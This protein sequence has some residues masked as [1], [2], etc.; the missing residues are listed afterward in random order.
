MRRALRFGVASL[1]R[2]PVLALAGWSVPE[3]VPATVSGLAVAHAVD[4]GFLAGRPLTGLGWLAVLL[5]AAVV[6]S[7][8]ARQGYRRLGDIVEPFRDDLVRR[9]VRGALRRG[10]AGQRDDGAVARLTHQ[11]EIVRDAYAGLIVV[12]RSFVIIVIGAVIGLLSLS[13]VIL[14]LVMPPF[15]VGFG[16]FL[17]TLGMAAA[18]QRD[19][20]RADERLASTAGAVLAGT[21]DVVACGIEDSATTMVAVP[22]AEQVAAERA[23]ARVQALRTVCYAVGGWVPLIVLLG[24]GPWLS[25][26]GLTTGDIMG[27]LLYVLTGLQPALHT[28]VQSMSGSGLRFAVVL[29]RILDVTEPESPVRAAATAPGPQAG[30][31][32]T[33]RGITFAYGPHAAPVLRGLDLDVPIGDHLAVVGPSGIGKSTLA[34]IVCGLLQPDRGTIAIGGAATGAMS[35]QRLAALRVLI[36]QEAYVFAGTV[37][38]NLTYL[39]PAATPEQVSAATAAVGADSLVVGLGGWAATVAPAELSAG[40]RQLL[41]LVRAY[42]SPAPIA[43]LDEATCHLDPAAERRAEEAFARRGGTLIVIAH[44]ISSALRARRILVL[45]GVSASVGDHAT[46]LAVSPLYRDLLGYWDGGEAGRRVP[47]PATAWPPSRPAPTGPAHAAP[48]AHAAPPARPAPSVRPAPSAP[49]PARPEV[50]SPARPDAPPV[51]SAQPAQI[52]QP[53]QIQPAQIQP[54]QIQPAS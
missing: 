5:A 44:R 38:D 47:P 27:G 42:L 43:V 53:A 28:V 9:V 21:R 7:I 4:S 30:Y 31:G 10:V 18:R 12:V 29:G 8:G 6:G 2:R 13:P 25:G 46:L 23:L 34:G 51:A 32:V 41:S 14:L 20:V 33:L 22:V 15:L 40:Q 24:A 36:P 11:V 19:Y 35:V 1:R 54:A 37:W 50:R 45:D 16:A 3:A 49:A 26:R 52:V 17:L 39:C 48:S